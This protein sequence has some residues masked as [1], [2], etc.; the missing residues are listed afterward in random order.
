M[1]EKI[2]RTCIVTR[3]A[4][5]ADELIRFVAAPDGAVV[6]DLRQKLP[7]RGC[8][9]TATRKTV[10]EAVKRKLFGRNLKEDVTVSPTLGAD[11]DQLMVKHFLGTLGLARKAGQLLTGAAK[12][13]SALRGAEAILVLHAFEAADDGVRKMDQARKA[14]AMTGGPVIPAFK[15]LTSVEM[16][17]AL[18]GGNVIH[19]AV[20]KGP[21]GSGLAKRAIAL[22]RYRGLED[23]REAL[24]I[25]R[26]AKETE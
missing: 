24:K 26:A 22:A 6:A 1:R 13:E 16:D 7:G 12:V 8:W 21:A 15:L 25:D 18:G 11:V 2:D 4:G 17:L 19:A 9:V 5:T 10:D 23:D 3:S 20:L 14:V